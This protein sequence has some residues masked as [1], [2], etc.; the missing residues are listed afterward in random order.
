MAREENSRERARYQSQICK[1][2]ETVKILDR[3]VKA[4]EDT[5]GKREALKV[6][7]EDNGTSSTLVVKQLQ[8]KVRVLESQLEKMKVK[9]ELEMSENKMAR[10]K[11]REHVE[12]VARRSSPSTSG[13]VQLVN[14]IAALSRAEQQVKSFN[15]ATTPKAPS[16][17]SSSS[18][19][20]ITPKTNRSVS[21]MSISPVYRR[22][23]SG[24]LDTRVQGAQTTLDKSRDLENKP[25]DAMWF[26]KVVCETVLQ[27]GG[28]RPK[29]DDDAFC[30]RS[31]ILAISELL[32]IKSWQDGLLAALGASSPNDAIAKA[33]SL[34]L[35]VTAQ[36]SACEDDDLNVYF[37]H[38]FE[39]VPGN[40]ARIKMTALFAER[41]E[42]TNIRARI[43]KSYLLPSDC[44]SRSLLAALG[45][46]E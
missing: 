26:R 5:R 18:S 8:V 36:H 4:L 43:S 17:T 14:T 21:S 38:L 10:D 22:D 3:Q 27:C 23:F 30:S 45:V 35:T 15:N 19:S 33:K 13:D 29:H 11:A 16:P 2:N 46:D 40:E 24:G 32:S 1:L 20:A 28:V 34:K 9:Y 7:M 39:S 42:W 41:L 44:T 6:V 12:R 31:V 37:L 25:G